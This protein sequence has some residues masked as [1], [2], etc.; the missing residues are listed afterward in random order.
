MEKDAA[1]FFG[2]P[3]QHCHPERSEVPAFVGVNSR[4]FV[5]AR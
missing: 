4:S 5:K 3:I 1:E 2:I